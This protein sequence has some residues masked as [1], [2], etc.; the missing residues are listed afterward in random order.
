[1]SGF[2]LAISLLPSDLIHLSS[3]SQSAHVARTHCSHHLYRDCTLA[4]KSVSSPFFRGLRS[5]SDLSR[6]PF[7]LFFLK[8]EMCDWLPQILWASYPGHFRLMPS[9]TSLWC[10]FISLSSFE[11]IRV[12]LGQE[13]VY[14]FSLTLAVV[15]L[16]SRHCSYASIISDSR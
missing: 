6:T 11:F 2:L 8:R 5:Y 9:S 12:N 3:R 10:I 16:R 7:C 13:K 4:N 14:I 1:M 15:S